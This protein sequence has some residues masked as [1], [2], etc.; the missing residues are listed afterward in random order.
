MFRKHILYSNL[1]RQREVFSFFKQRKLEP[2]EILF[3]QVTQLGQVR[4]RTHTQV[5][6]Y[7]IWL[8]FHNIEHAS[9]Q[10]V[11]YKWKSTSALSF[12][13]HMSFNILVSYD[14]VQRSEEPVFEWDSENNE[15]TDEEDPVNNYVL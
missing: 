12:I 13:F 15:A 9:L 11:P 4:A 6:W 8:V 1:V 5:F 7:Q 2:C 3:A 10:S 14:F